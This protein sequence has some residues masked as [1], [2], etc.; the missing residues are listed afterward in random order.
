[1]SAQKN[2]GAMTR[3][4]GVKEVEG[5]TN[6]LFITHHFWSTLYER[7]PN[8]RSRDAQNWI[9]LTILVRISYTNDTGHYG[10]GRVNQRDSGCILH[11]RD[12]RWPV[13]GGMSLLP[14]T[15]RGITTAILAA[16][17][18]LTTFT[19]V[20]K[21]TTTHTMTLHTELPAR[22]IAQA[23]HGTIVASARLILPARDTII[24]HD[25]IA[26]TRVITRTIPSQRPRQSTAQTTIP[27]AAAP[28]IE[29]PPS[30]IV[31]PPLTRT[32]SFRD[33]TFV[34]I[35]A[36]VITAPPDSAPLG[37]TYHLTRPRFDPTITFI[38]TTSHPLV[39]VSWQGERITLDHVTIPSTEPRWIRT[40][41]VSYT[42]TAKTVSM[43]GTI[44]L[45]LFAGLD[46]TASMTQPLSPNA[47]SFP[48]PAMTLRKRF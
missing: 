42:P 44:G 45:R 8:Q 5:V 6:P 9:H 43:A 2:C 13:I 39:V 10:D 29:R 31:A 30:S 34:G 24:V 26:T 33:S 32:A 7:T 48:I 4:D 37:I 15:P 47:L 41:D 36:G 46:L 12:R 3:S 19:I 14:R 1:M 35:I 16:I 23:G 28:P 40:V 17:A 25:T 22:V 21:C 38:T 11:A 20:E 27:P 18:W